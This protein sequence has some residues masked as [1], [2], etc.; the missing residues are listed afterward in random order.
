MRK[1]ILFF[2][3]NSFVFQDLKKNIDKKFNISFFSRK[4]DQI[5]SFELLKSKWRII[6]SNFVKKYLK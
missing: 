1:K 5:R 2:G 4:K 3:Y 6:K